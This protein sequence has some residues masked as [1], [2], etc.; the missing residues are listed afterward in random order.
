MFTNFAGY[1]IIWRNTLQPDSPQITTW[2]M[3]IARSITDATNTISECV[4]LNCFCKARIVARKRFS[5]TFYVYTLS[6][7]WVTLYYFLWIPHLAK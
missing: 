5:V 3:R 2:H 6:V 7:L 4:L 1:E